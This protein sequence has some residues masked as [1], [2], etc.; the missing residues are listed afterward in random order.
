MLC[1]LAM[2]KVVGSSPIIRSLL[3]SRGLIEFRYPDGTSVVGEYETYA[4]RHLSK[5]D[6]LEFDGA[7]W[8]MCDREDRGGITVYLFSPTSES[9]PVVV[10]PTRRARRRSHLSN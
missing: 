9:D 2:Q 4:A 1:S 5:G 7:E 6:R 8:A 3:D 10:D